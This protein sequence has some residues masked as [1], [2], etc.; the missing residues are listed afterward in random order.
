MPS[1][2]KGTSDGWMNES[3][4]KMICRCGH[5]KWYHRKGSGKCMIIDCDCEDYAK[6]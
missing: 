4:N 6:K 2:E 5:S 3:K 1:K